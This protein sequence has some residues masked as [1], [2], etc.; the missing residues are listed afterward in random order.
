MPIEKNQVVLFHYS[1]SDDQGN[2]IESSR[3][4]KPN[5]YLHGHGGVIRG[6]E[7]ALEGRETGES[8][9]VTVTPD[10]AY[11]PRKPDAVQR[12]PVKHLLGAKRWKPG[13]IAQVQTEQ[14]A[15]HVVVAKVGHKFADVDT[16]HPMAGKTLTFDVEII[17]VRAAEPEEIAHGHAHGPGGHH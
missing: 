16:N 7:E 6:L 17:E 2:T 9:S 12:V 5:A 8:F 13:M 10:K 14:G 1:V 11:G 15:R 3:D 4:G